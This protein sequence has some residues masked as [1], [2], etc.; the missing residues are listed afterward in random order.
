MTLTHEGLNEEQT[1]QHAEGWEHY[2]ERLQK[3]ATA[4]DA[5]P[6]EFAR[7]PQDLN[8]VTATE[9]VLS[10]VQPVLRLL[11]P[12]GPSRSRRRARTSTPTTS[13]TT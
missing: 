1:K 9:S 5:G 12:R 13:S 6:D 4:G 2:L 10:A 7:V 8:P 11:G 3:V